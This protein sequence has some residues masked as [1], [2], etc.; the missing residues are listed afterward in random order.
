MKTLVGIP[1]MDM[2]H[3]AFMRSV[4]C[5]Q[6][7]QECE[8]TLASG[9]LIYDARNQIA[10]KAVKGGFD[11]VLWLDS[12][13]TFERDTLTRL[14]AHIDSGL[15]FISGLYF[16]RKKPIKPV[17]YKSLTVEERNGG[18]VPKIESYTDYPKNSLFEIEGCGFGCCLVK[19]SLIE[20]VTDKFGLPFFPAAGFGEDFAFCYRVKELGV[21]MFCDSSIKPEH[22]AYY[23][24]TEETY[25]KGEF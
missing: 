1:C 13:M 3:T 11:Q 23:P 12:D 18:Y 19:T 7:P 2:V 22:L 15:E 8:I 5:L 25:L 17:I 24:V 6:Y 21:K 4:L 10:E 16:A 14:Q 9:S 20:R